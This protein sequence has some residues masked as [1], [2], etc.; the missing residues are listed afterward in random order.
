MFDEMDEAP[1][2]IKVGTDEFILAEEAD[3]FLAIGTEH[4]GRGQEGDL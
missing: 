3:S 2:V 4:L 1:T